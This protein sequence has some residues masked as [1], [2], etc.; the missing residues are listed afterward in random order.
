MKSVLFYRKKSNRH[1]GQ[2][3]RKHCVF[4]LKSQLGEVF[5]LT[6][7]PV[8]ALSV[9]LLL[10]FL[11]PW[12]ISSAF[13]A[14]CSGPQS[15]FCCRSLHCGLQF[16]HCLSPLGAARLLRPVVLCNWS[17]RPWSFLWALLLGRRDLAFSHPREDVR[18]SPACFTRS[19]SRI[20]RDS[21]PLRN[22]G[23][24]AVLTSG[25][26]RDQGGGLREGRT[27]VAQ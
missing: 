22:I 20:F 1:V 25:G 10:S 6:G 18:C 4:H 12:S 5:I 19:C 23:R 17:C 7:P 3:N 8:S 27:S 2:P 11:M 21:F 14:R 9:G 16:Q 24:A 26:F 15:Q 13:L